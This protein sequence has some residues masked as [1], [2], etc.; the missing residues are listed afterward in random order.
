M[1]EYSKQFDLAIEN[2][3]DN[4]ESLRSTLPGILGILKKQS[5]KHAVEH[6]KFLDKECE[7]VP[8]K[9][10]YLII[11]ENSRRNTV[12]KKAAIQSQIAH[13]M[14]SRNFL[15]SI[16][17]QFDT[18]IGQLMN[19][20]FEIK[21][22]IIDNSERQLSF[23]QLRTFPSVLDAR[24]YIVEKEV[25]SVLRDSHSEQFSWF[26]KK[27]DIKLRSDL[28]AW[29]DFIELTQ[30][31]NLFVHNNGKVSSQYI[32]VCKL[33]EVSL[34]DNLKIGDE[35]GSGLDYFEN[36]FNCLFE[37]GLKLNQVLR[38]KLLPDNIEEADN[39]FLNITFDLIQN[40]QL[41]LAKELYDFADKYIRKYSK[42]DIEL[43]ILLNRAQTYKWLGNEDKCC[44][45]IKSKDW[46]AYGE[47]F[48]L[49]SSVLINDYDSAVSSMKKIGNNEEIVKKYCYSDWPI[50]KEFI[51]TDHFK[52]TYK[53]IYGTDATS[54]EDQNATQ[55]TI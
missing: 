54:V 40:D 18:Y 28:P 9:N 35:L 8:K 1:K 50:F 41:K 25:E 55:Q 10:H 29:K 16:V 5:E 43:R 48:K 11:P 31:R 33:H 24:S 15:I 30:R 36:A 3:I 45:I 17:S 27:L 49:S 7:Y 4:I 22:E 46:S 44:N 52:A 2:Y 37:I 38:R 53:E 14:M 51:Q 34:S 12:L 19:C 13:T 6:Q 32:N 42:L 23:S 39:S 47:L 20:I 21:P 26:E